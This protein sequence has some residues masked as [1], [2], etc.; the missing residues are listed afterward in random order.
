MIQRRGISTMCQRLAYVC[1]LVVAL[2]LAGCTGS[3]PSQE[4][5]KADVDQIRQAVQDFTVA[6]NAKDVA[7]IGTFFANG[8]ALMPPN[9]STQ[10]GVDA[11]KSWYQVRV[12]E[13]GA[14]DLVIET[15]S[16]DGH[17]LLAYVVGTYSL[18]LKPAD[19]T[20]ARHDR[21]RVVWI[22]RKLGGQWKFEWQIM[23]SDLPPV[24]SQPQ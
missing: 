20:L 13:E 12:T 6:Y 4:F 16:V 24:I 14:T 3:A 19:G 21:G 15:Q 10:R 1:A 8:A 7:K 11:V 22:M 2:S 17:G 18:N 23:A 9:R 5:G